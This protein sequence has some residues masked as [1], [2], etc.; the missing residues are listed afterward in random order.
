MTQERCGILAAPR[1][2]SVLE[3]IAKPSHEV[4]SVLFKALGTIRTIFFLNIVGLSQ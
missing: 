3:L 1:I 2:V 4:V